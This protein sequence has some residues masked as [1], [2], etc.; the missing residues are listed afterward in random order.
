MAFEPKVF[1]IVII[2][3]IKK[4]EFKTDKIRQLQGATKLDIVYLQ[5][6]LLPERI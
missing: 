6:I 1:G 4:L 5:N 3:V 2:L